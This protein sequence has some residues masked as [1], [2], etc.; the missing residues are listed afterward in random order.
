MK[1]II[2]S[3]RVSYDEK[4]QSG[5]LAAAIQDTFKSINGMWI[6]WSGEISEEV[7]RKNGKYENM[8]I[9]NTKFFR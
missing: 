8:K 4:P 1:L 5:G 2:V 3:N 9:L 6:G 7:Q